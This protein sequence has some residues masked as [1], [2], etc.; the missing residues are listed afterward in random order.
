MRIC[1][2]LCTACII[3]L[4]TSALCDSLSFIWMILTT[5]FCIRFA[6]R[7]RFVQDTISG[8]R[9]LCMLSAL[10]NFTSSRSW[11]ASSLTRVLGWAAPETMAG[12][13]VT[14]SEDLSQTEANSI[15]ACWTNELL[16]PILSMTTLAVD[17]LHHKSGYLSKYIQ[18]HRGCKHIKCIRGRKSCWFMLYVC[19]SFSAINSFVDLS[20]WSIITW[21]ASL[22]LLFIQSKRKVAGIP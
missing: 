9:R 19:H 15:A 11:I 7:A 3:C 1:L 10:Y 14:A 4:L 18:A 22:C 20:L 17:F 13:I 12:I 5:H 8:C 2:P 16:D 6:N 21:P